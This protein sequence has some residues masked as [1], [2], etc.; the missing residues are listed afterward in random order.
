[1]LEEIVSTMYGKGLDRC[2]TDELYGA[3]LSLVQ[4][5]AGE[6]E[7]RGKRKNCII[8]QRSF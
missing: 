4:R 3:L 8:F 2:S 6:R 1:M 7:I 5:K